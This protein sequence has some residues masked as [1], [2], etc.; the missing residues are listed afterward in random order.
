MRLFILIILGCLLLN[1]CNDEPSTDTTKEPEASPQ[2]KLND[3]LDKT[4]SDQGIPGI[5]AAVITSDSVR[6]MESAG[7]RKIN[8]S[9]SLTI[10]DIMHL[11]SCTKAM[12]SALLSI[13]VEEEYINWETTLLEVFPELKDVIHEDYHDITLHQLVTHRSGVAANPADWWLY[14]DLEIKERRIALLKENLRDPSKIP[15]G[16]YTYSNLGY[17]IAGSMA[18]RVTGETW[19]VLM[20]DRLFGPLG[21]S[22]AGFGAPGTPGETDQPWG[23]GKSGGSWNPSQTDNAEAL[24][25]AG[26]VHCDF[27]DWAK[28]VSVFLP[29][30][31]TEVLTPEQVDF[32]T[33]PTGEYA[34]GWIVVDRNWAGGKALTHTGSNTMWFALVWIAPELDRAYMVGFN[35]Y[36]DDSFSIAD[37]IIGQLIG[38][39]EML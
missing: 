20:N 2:V 9:D 14:Q 24:G 13:L 36:D 12:T 18:E 26:R 37:D 21:M 25:P 7:L 33:L 16:T 27:S 8:S 30:S 22:T 35:S 32:L 39:D 11:G 28:F 23:H 31:D 6:M 1:S 4:V 19:E 15:V 34:S 29:F 10:N 5:L 38:L 17:M 3:L